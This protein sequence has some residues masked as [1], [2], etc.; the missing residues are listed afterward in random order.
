MKKVILINVILSVLIF[1]CSSSTVEYLPTVVYLKSPELVNVDGK[2]QTYVEFAV[3]DLNESEGDVE[4][5]FISQNNNIL[6][7]TIKKLLFSTDGTI[8]S[9]YHEELIITEEFDVEIKVCNLDKLCREQRFEAVKLNTE[10][11]SDKVNVTGQ[12]ISDNNNFNT[13]IILSS[14]TKAFSPDKETGIFEIN[15]IDSGK[16]NL[17]TK[18]EDISDGFYRYIYLKSINFNKSTKIYLYTPLEENQEYDEPIIDCSFSSESDTNYIFLILLVMLF[19]I[20]F[21]INEGKKF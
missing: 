9:F 2:N 5:K 11:E 3:S 4:I 16:Y 13:S 19:V 8:I 20:K 18:G 15:E 6:E 1:G 7:K 21:R 10:L 12:M 14:N 17:Y